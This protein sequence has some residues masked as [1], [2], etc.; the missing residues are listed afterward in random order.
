MCGYRRRHLG[1]RE[2]LCLLTIQSPTP[3]LICVRTTLSC[4]FLKQSE[5]KATYPMAFLPRLGAGTNGAAVQFIQCLYAQQTILPRPQHK[6]G[7]NLILKGPV[8]IS[9]GKPSM[10][11]PFVP[12]TS[13]STLLTNMPGQ[14]DAL[15]AHLPF[16]NEFPSLS[17]KV[18]APLV[19]L[20]PPVTEKQTLPLQN[21]VLSRSARLLE[22]HTG[23]SKR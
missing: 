13:L 22:M 2:E 18:D 11:I 12:K 9:H 15:Y 19:F 14:P 3:T 8:S 5:T 6:W 16:T 1:V 17:Q 20:P 21:T 7:K 4:R 10:G 23:V